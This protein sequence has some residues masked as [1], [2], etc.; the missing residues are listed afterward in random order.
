MSFISAALMAF[1]IAV[2]IVFNNCATLQMAGFEQ[3]QTRQVILTIGG[4][5]TEPF[6]IPEYWPE[7]FETLPFGLTPIIPP[8]LI[9]YTLNKDE[10]HL[11]SVLIHIGDR[12]IY[13]LAD[14]PMNEYGKWKEGEVTWYLMFGGKPVLSSENEVKGL[15]QELLELLNRAPLNEVS[16]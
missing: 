14:H 2:V 9:Y 10:S 15:I 4:F 8:F 6:S 3:L 1:L 11:Y 16:C 12:K 13:A 7:D 5:E